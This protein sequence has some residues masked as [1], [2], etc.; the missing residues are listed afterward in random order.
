MWQTDALRLWSIEFATRTV[1][2]GSLREQLSA[3]SGQ[4]SARIVIDLSNHN[5]AKRVWNQP[6]G[7]MESMQSIAWNQPNAAWN[8]PQVA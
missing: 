1:V 7:C 4:Q 2:R 8:Q 6:L 5:H 3:V